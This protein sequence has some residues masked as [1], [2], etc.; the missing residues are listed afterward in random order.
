MELS[1]V[2]LRVDNGFDEPMIIGINS[3][4]DGGVGM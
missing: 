1:F 3:N 4:L 2:L